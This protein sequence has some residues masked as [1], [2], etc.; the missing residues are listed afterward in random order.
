MAVGGPSARVRWARAAA[1][2]A[3]IG[4]VVLCFVSPWGPRVLWTML[5][6]PL[7]LFMIVAG[8]HTWRSL[9]PL[10]LLGSLGVRL[11][12]VAAGVRGALG[13]GSGPEAAPPRRV[14]AWL[15]RWFFVVSL[16]LLMAMMVARLV[17]LNGDGPWLGATLIGIAALAAAANF[18]FGG[19]A[20]CNYLCPVGVVERIF[21]DPTTRA[22]ASSRCAACTACKKNCPDIDQEGAYWKDV[23]GPS[24]RAAFYAYPGAVL[25]YYL[26]YWLRDGR[27]EG[28]LDGSWL[29][30]PADARL[31]FA[32]GY[33]FLPRVPAVAAASLTMV[34]LALASYCLFDVVEVLAARWVPDTEHRRH[35]VLGLAAFAGL[36]LFYAFAGAPTLIRVPGAVPVAAL[37]VLSIATWVLARRRRRTSEAF[38]QA[39]GARRLIPLWPLDTPPP[40]DP[41]AVLAFFKGQEHARGAQVNAYRA[42]MNDMLADGT[43]RSRDVRLLDRLRDD[44]GIREADDRKLVAELP[45]AQRQA[46]EAKRAAQLEKRSRRAAGEAPP[47]AGPSRAPRRA[48]PP[49]SPPER[50]RR[51]APAT[52]LAAVPGWLVAGALFAFALFGRARRDG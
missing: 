1:L 35:W 4:V 43:V 15:D 24:R 10:A 36:N 9:C 2:A 22:T 21:T 11:R 49:S 23:T 19:K 13:L 50:D 44:L 42:A 33:F 37:A 27:W 29:R 45:E 25:G 20:W 6:P 8:F 3:Y 26:F 28:Y 40:R 31:A 46:L 17:L 47:A 16:G 48:P 41:A 34:L 38:A 39:R 18:A 51:S 12:P 52:G 7:P 5:L 14:P 30:S 32:P